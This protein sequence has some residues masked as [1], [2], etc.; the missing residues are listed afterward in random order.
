[1]RLT[2]SYALL[3]LFLSL[4]DVLAARLL[5]RDFQKLKEFNRLTK[6][7]SSELLL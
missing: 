7:I 2:Y 3:H 5:V 1:M 4:P 6:N